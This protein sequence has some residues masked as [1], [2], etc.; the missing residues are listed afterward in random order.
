M[1]RFNTDPSNSLAL[2]QNTAS[3]SI[4]RCTYTPQA[5]QVSLFLPLFL[6]PLNKNQGTYH[7]SRTQSFY[8]CIKCLYGREVHQQMKRRDDT[9]LLL[10]PFFETENTNTHTS[11]QCLSLFSPPP[12]YLQNQAVQERIKERRELHVTRK[13]DLFVVFL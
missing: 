11:P 12:L 8:V 6:F 1:D 3:Y 9:V 2:G 5:P 4:S 10:L 13:L 7:G